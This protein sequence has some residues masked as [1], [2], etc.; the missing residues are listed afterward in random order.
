MDATGWFIAIGFALRA[1]KSA[2]VPARSPTATP[3]TRDALAA[4]TPSTESAT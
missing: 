1:L 2:Y 4:R 3:T